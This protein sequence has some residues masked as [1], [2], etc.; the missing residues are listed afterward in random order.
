MSN[1]KQRLGIKQLQFAINKIGVLGSVSIQPED[2]SDPTNVKEVFEID[3]SSIDSAIS[4]EENRATAAETSLQTA[5]NNVQADVNQ[6]EADADAAI[7]AVQADVDQNESDADAAIA[8]LQ[9]E[10]ADAWDD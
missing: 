5:I 8:A 9:A 7:A 4:A 3:F 1:F 6:N 2:A 10:I